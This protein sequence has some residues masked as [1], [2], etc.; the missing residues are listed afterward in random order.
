MNP[1]MLQQSLINLNNPPDRAI[2][3]ICLDNI[4]YDKLYKM[5]N[6][7]DVFVCATRAEAFNLPGIEAMACGLPTIQTN[8][9][10][11][12]DYMTNK[13]SL[14]INYKLEEV[15]D[16]IMYEGVEWAVPYIEHIK[17]EM[18]W[19]FNNQDKV[20][21]MGKQALEDVKKWTWE[22]SAKKLVEHLK[23]IKK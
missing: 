10:G 7:A 18:R 15:K 17:N 21:E 19:C 22:L 4:P 13:N 9:G 11:Q 5:Y 3:K 14:F 12:T 1:Q 2:T 16:D 20:K 6:D 23:K 8:Y